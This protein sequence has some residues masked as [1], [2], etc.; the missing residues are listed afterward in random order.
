VILETHTKIFLGSFKWYFLVL[1]TFANIEI[2]NKIW[3]NKK[4]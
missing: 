4:R 1:T 3:Y 2:I